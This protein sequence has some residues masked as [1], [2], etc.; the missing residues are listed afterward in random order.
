MTEE[1]DNVRKDALAFLKR[2][3]TGVLATRGEAV[4]PHAS[5]VYYT[6]DDDFNIY[7]VTLEN[8]RKFKALSAHPQVAFVVATPDVPQ[9]LQIEGMAVDITTDT[10][11]AQKKDEIMQVLNSN[12]NFYAPITKMDPSEVVVVWL[13]PTW[14]RWSDFA[15]E[16]SGNQHVFK[17]IP[18]R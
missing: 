7:F 9:T 4:G 2:H 5:M 13:R 17:E 16:E 18:I 3:K 6:A 1:M 14:V 15:F 11:V 8:S 10:Q 12:P